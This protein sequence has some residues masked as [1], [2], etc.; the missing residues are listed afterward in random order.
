MRDN[1]IDAVAGILTIHVILG[2]IFQ[3]SHMNSYYAPVTRIFIFFMPWFFYKS[4][5]F[6]RQKSVKDTIK[7]VKKLLV[8]FVAFSLIGQFVWSIMMFVNGDR[9]WE[10]YV[11]SHIKTLIAEGAMNGNLP[12]WFLLSLSV[13]QIIFAKVKNKAALL[14]AAMIM[15]CALS[16]FDYSKPYLIANSFSGLFFYVSGYYL[17]EYQYK[18][19]VALISIF[20]AVIIY[21]CFPSMVDMRSNHILS[22]N[23]VMWLLYSISGI[24]TINNFFKYFKLHVLGKILVF[25]GRNSMTFYVLHWIVMTIVLTI[26]VI[27]NVKT[28]FPWMAILVNAI[29]LSFIS[30]RINKTEN[31]IIKELFGTKNRS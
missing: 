15:S 25:V 26:C 16:Y 13:V 12:L 8:P 5:M 24:I 31:K 17:K 22:G 27:L 21:I 9:E 30:L 23:Y 19:P 7:S 11:L 29:L 1:S 3:W 18:K 2:H 10:Y 28:Y 4:G 6:C 14:M 20:V